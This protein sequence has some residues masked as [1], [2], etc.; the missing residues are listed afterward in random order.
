[1]KI[2]NTAR[3][4]TA[5]RILPIACASAL[6]GPVSLPASAYADFV[7]P[8]SVPADIQVPEG[9]E[10]FLKAHASGTQNYICLPSDSGFAWTFFGPQ[11]TLFN[12]YN[13]QVIT[14]FLSPNPFEKETSRVTWQHSRDTST[15]WGQ[16]IASSS[17]PAFV[18]PDAIP[19]LLVQVVGAQDGPTGG[20]AL[21]P[22][23]FIQ[24]LNT[25]G[26]VA[27]S[28]GCA[29]PTDVGQ[30][31]LVPYKAEYFFYKPDEYRY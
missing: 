19:W 28:T 6:A 29:E 9:N 10:P 17:D 25:V 14:H 24:R 23:T 12:R 8:P 15:V 3:N 26:G 4:Q 13:Q 22:T 21:T 7:T 16:G 5:R 30:K 1:M 27:P 31:A 20:H 18:A 11:A 2:G